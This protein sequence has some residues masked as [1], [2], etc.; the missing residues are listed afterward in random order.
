MSKVIPFPAN[1]QALGQLNFSKT[2]SA[3]API[4]VGV[5]FKA[6]LGNNTHFV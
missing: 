1:R 3:P 5:F 6:Y 4:G 2:L